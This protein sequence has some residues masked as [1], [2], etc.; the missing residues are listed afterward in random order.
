MCVEL[1]EVS[2]FV[3]LGVGDFT[4]E[5]ATLKA[6]SSKVAKHEKTCYDNQHIFIPFEF[7]IFLLP[8][9]RGY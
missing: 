9:T 3:R 1:I 6:A 7:D 2:P 4:S 5:H 8:D